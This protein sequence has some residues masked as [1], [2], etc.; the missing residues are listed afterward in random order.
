MTKQTWPA[1]ERNKDPILAVLEKELPSTGLLLEVASGTGQHAVHFA[2]NLPAW[3][4]QPSDFDPENLASIS[5]WVDESALP[6]LNAPIALDVRDADWGIAPLD[7]IFCANM[8][9]I[10]PWECAIALIEGAGRHLR[11]GGTLVIYGPFKLGGSHTAPS[12]ADFD[13]SLRERNPDWGVRD[14]EAIEELA[15]ACSLMPSS[16]IP[17]PA[18]NQS[19]IFRKK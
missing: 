12:N 1:P 10:A 13:R 11:Q 15:A 16:R 17:M 14:A 4:I 18:N 19:L 2:Q 5:A 6:N 9:H 7:A 8:V 3:T